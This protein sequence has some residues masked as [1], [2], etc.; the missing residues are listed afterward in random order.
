[1]PAQWSGRYGPNNDV[2]F[3]NGTEYPT[4]DAMSAATGSGGNAPYGS[5]R[6]W[7]GGWSGASD[8][9]RSVMTQN[10]TGPLSMGGGG[11]GV[12]ATP[13][14]APPTPR[15]QPPSGGTPPAGGGTLPQTGTAGPSGTLPTDPTYQGFGDP[16]EPWTDPRGSVVRGLMQMGYNP[17]FGGAS[18]DWLMKRADDIVN[19]ALGRAAGGQGGGI[20]VLA[21]PGGFQSMIQNTLQDA[22]MGR[23]G[24]LGGQQ[25]NAQNLTRINQIIQSVMQGTGTPS[26]GAAILANM[27]R[28]DPGS[29]A[30]L[31]GSLLYGNL[32]QNANAALSRPL[33]LL[34]TAFQMQGNTP[35]GFAQQMNRS[36]LDLLLNSFYPQVALWGTNPG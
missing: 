9:D 15:D 12:F 1:M 32:G 6:Y 16:F 25:Q 35:A 17:A 23:Q 7:P 29:V 27:F 3:Y 14:M 18:T 2:W 26:P 34:P 28:S 4:F 10:P 31:V 8:W 5:A 11:G 36:P 30:G 33:A 20:D 19:S 21:T 22:A 13:Q 24:P